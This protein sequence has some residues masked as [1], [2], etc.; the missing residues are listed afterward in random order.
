MRSKKEFIGYIRMRLGEPVIRVEITDE[1]ISSIID[2]TVKMF[3]DVVYGDF[4]ETVMISAEQAT[5]AIYL[6]KM[7]SIIRVQ[8]SDDSNYVRFRNPYMA[9]LPS[10]LISR[11]EKRKEVQYH[12]SDIKRTLTIK[13]AIIPDPMI[14]IGM[15][16]YQPN[17]LEDHI[18]EEIWIQSMAKAKSQKMWGQVVGKFS[19]NLV[20]GATINFDRIIQEADSE[21][22]L[23]MAELD[24]KYTDPAPVFVI[25]S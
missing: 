22:E 13:D 20:G 3:T 19:Q 9:A 18:F 4:E 2:D 1:Q 7:R 14:V 8:S 5:D 11:Q 21:I 12:W 15:T 16:R 25:S 24:D 6:P 10:G 23:L 17:D